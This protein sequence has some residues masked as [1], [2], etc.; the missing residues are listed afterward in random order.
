MNFGDP[1][2]NKVTLERL[3]KFSANQWRQELGSHMP[4][5]SL[6]TGACST[7]LLCW[8]IAKF[9]G[10]IQPAG[11]VGDSISGWIF[12][13]LGALGLATLKWSRV[14]YA[15]AA[16]HLAATAFAAW[17]CVIAFAL[18][19]TAAV[20]NL[21]FIASLVLSFAVPML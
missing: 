10:N 11:A 12:S 14:G 2:G 4:K 17:W 1:E 9:L 16:T 18:W 21:G 7:I 20:T 8:G 13:G 6:I 5:W 19:R 15:A 3:L